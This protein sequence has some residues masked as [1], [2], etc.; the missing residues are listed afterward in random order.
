[1]KTKISNPG[2]LMM[3]TLIVIV[4]GMLTSCSS[5]KMFTGKM[6]YSYYKKVKVQNKKD[7][8]TELAY[9]R[10][11]SQ[12]SEK[13]E[14][15]SSHSDNRIPVNSVVN[16][17]DIVSKK[18]DNVTSHSAFKETKA[19]FAPQNKNDKRKG[20]LKEKIVRRFVNQPNVKSTSKENGKWFWII[21]LI[22]VGG[23]IL[24]TL[25]IVLIYNLLSS[26]GPILYF[27]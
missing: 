27:G 26:M 18:Q 10:T 2:N 8:I 14:I 5:N 24:W 11:I 16:N 1:M 19:A 20:I 12:D 17:D 23:I 4:C 6:K 22:V 13:I 21:F 25:V 3:I 15:S 9:N 7:T